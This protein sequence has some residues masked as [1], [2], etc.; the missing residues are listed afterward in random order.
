MKKLYRS[1]VILTLALTILAFNFIVERADAQTS[2]GSD[3][4][5][6]KT[7]DTPKKTADV[8]SKPTP[9]P[10]DAP[11][12]DSK[13]DEKIIVTATNVIIR[14][15]ASAKSA[16]LTAVKLGKI[17]PVIE[18]GSAF[19]Q[20]EYEAGKNGWISTTFTRDYNADKRDAT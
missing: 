11:K 17:L 1:S 15:E 20:V 12:S 18:R 14:K 2:I 5:N 8:K 10:A 3:K 16:R 4:P 7:K 6:P 19:Y 9:K 13:P